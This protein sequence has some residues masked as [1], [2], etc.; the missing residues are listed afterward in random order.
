[1]PLDI[2]GQGSKR[3]A[4]RGRVLDGAVVLKD[5]FAGLTSQDLWK[6]LHNYGR[7]PGASQLLIRDAQHAPSAVAYPNHEPYAFGE[8]VVLVMA[9]RCQPQP[10]AASHPAPRA[11]CP[12]CLPRVLLKGEG[13]AVQEDCNVPPVGQ[14]KL[15]VGLTPGHSFAPVQVSKNPL[16]LQ[17]APGVAPPVELTVQGGQGDARK[18]ASLIAEL[19]NAIGQVWICYRDNIL[20]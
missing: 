1:M 11:A 17:R 3:L 13:Y 18:Q 19:P 5:K 4:S 7:K 10:L 15:G 2:S 14:R 6:V 20:N 12:G 16:P 8:G 9:L